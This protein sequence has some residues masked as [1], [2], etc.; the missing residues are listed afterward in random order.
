M[1]FFDRSSYFDRSIE[2]WKKELK[3]QNLVELIFFSFQGI[4][5]DVLLIIIESNENHDSIRIFLNN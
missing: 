4:I 5:R 2:T 1:E 3:N